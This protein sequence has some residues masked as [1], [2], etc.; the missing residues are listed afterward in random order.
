MQPRYMP[1]MITRTHTWHACCCMAAVMCGMYVSMRAVS[2]RRCCQNIA[3]RKPANLQA[4]LQAWL[5]CSTTLIPHR[6]N[7]IA[8][9]NKHA[10]LCTWHY[11]RPKRLLLMHCSYTAIGWGPESIATSSA[12]AAKREQA[13]PQRRRTARLTKQQLAWK[14]LPEHWTSLAATNSWLLHPAVPITTRA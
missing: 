10:L 9:T 3:Q 6:L 4:C 7:G 14:L 5:R 13:V 12:T 1:V 8:W 2:L 11:E